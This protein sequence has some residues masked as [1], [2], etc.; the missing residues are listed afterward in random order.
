MTRDYDIKNAK[1]LTTNSQLNVSP[2]HDPRVATA[3]GPSGQREVVI[4]LH[5]PALAA[6]ED[7]LVFQRV[8]AVDGFLE[9]RHRGRVIEVDLLAILEALD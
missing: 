8:A 4:G 6:D 2:E 5:D 9:V 7:V 1:A 3:E